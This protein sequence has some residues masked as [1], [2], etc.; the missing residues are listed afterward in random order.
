MLNLEDLTAT[1]STTVA[2][3]QSLAVRKRLENAGFLRKSSQANPLGLHQGPYLRPTLPDAGLLDYRQIVDNSGP[4]AFMA[5]ADGAGHLPI[6]H[7]D[8]G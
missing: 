5:G 2:G 4:Y 3:R 1:E 6:Q 8:C 7:I